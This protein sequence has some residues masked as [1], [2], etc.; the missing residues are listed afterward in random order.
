M[1]YFYIHSI[2]YYINNNRD[3]NIISI[4]NK[5]ENNKLSIKQT[6]SDINLL[7]IYVIY[8]ILTSEIIE[9][10]D[11][12]KNLETAKTKIVVLYRF[13]SG[14]TVQ[15]L[16]YTYKYIINNNISSKFIG[17]WEDDTIFKDDYFLETVEKYLNDGY[18]FIGSLWG[19]R[20]G[21]K[22]KML[23]INDL[24]PK[25]KYN[26]LYVD[27]PDN[28]NLVTDLS[29]NWC[30]DPYVTTIDNL[31]LIE[32][33]LGKFTLAN[34]ND[35]YTHCEHGI[36]YGEVG[37]P[38]RLFLNG[39]KFYGLQKSKYFISLQEQSIGNKII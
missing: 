26:M 16:Y 9:K 31:K 34:E 11:S 19:D 25:I 30:E 5:L 38:T 15:T 27:E 10:F 24:V 14:G 36:N 6:N 37:F 22:T 4:F 3:N 1:D 17:I 35:T 32:S 33:K 20:D 8:D 29:Y 28:Y 12:Y 2:S 7:I 23:D 13:N 18:I 21:I 39:F